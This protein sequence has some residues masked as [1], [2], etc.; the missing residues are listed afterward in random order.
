MNM[1]KMDGK[2]FRK[3]TACKENRGVKEVSYAGI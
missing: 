2:E 3:I 1:L